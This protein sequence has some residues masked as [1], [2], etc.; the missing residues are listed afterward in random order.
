[1]VAIVFGRRNAKAPQVLNTSGAGYSFNGVYL[2]GPAPPWRARDS[3]EE[4]SHKAARIARYC[5]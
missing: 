1:M 5:R 3:L 4:A 2:A